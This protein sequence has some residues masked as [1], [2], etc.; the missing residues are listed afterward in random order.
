MH[1]LAHI[2]INKWQVIEWFLNFEPY[3][4][5]MVILYD[6]NMLKALNSVYHVE[7]MKRNTINSLQ[8]YDIQARASQI[9]CSFVVKKFPTFAQT[10]G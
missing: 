1:S 4:Q 9:L 6:E 8:Q 3:I 2:P 7:P 10:A 5:Q